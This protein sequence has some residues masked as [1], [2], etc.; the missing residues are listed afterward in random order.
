MIGMLF[1]N[2]HWIICSITTSKRTCGW[3]SLFLYAVNQ[4]A[5]FQFSWSLFLIQH[6]DGE[7]ELG[8]WEKVK[9]SA[10]R[11]FH[12]YTRTSV[13]L[14]LNML[15]LKNDVA[16][17][18]FVIRLTIFQPNEHEKWKDNESQQS[19][20][21]ILSPSRNGR[22]TSQL[23][24]HVTVKLFLLLLKTRA[25]IRERIERLIIIIFLFY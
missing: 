22:D 14:T 19:V 5:Q 4:R 21:F 25:E 7:V 2:L 11:A 1:L 24:L 6:L 13:N 23:Y 18:S 9:M 16:L 10:E 3:Q 15:N 12:N 8:V 20:W 17:T